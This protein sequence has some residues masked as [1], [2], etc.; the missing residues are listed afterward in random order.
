MEERRILRFQELLRKG[1]KIERDVLPIINKCIDGMEKAAD[2]INPKSV[3]MDY[4]TIV[5][6]VIFQYPL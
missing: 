6:V 2:S 1:A 3:K 5:Y 4:K